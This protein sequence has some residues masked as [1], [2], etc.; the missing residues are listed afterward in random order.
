MADTKPDLFL[1]AAGVCNACRSYENR[2]SID[3]GA[4]KK[5]LLDLI[6]R[7]KDALGCTERI[8]HVGWNQLSQVS[9][10]P[11]CAGTP[12]GT[13]FYFVHSFAFDV[14]DAEDVVASVDYDV[15]V[16]AAVARG[17]ALGLQHH[18]EKSAKA[19]FRQ[20]RNFLEMI[21]C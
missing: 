6:L 14:Q 17:N 4:R 9:D 2:K 1:D 21:P 12:A 13:D 15:S 3:W 18:P 19:G 7:Y 10:H 20:I 5:E 11:L 16:A 8:L